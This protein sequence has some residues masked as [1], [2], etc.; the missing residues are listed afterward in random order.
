MKTFFG[1]TFIDK[2]AL[3]EA[4]IY[5]PIKLEYYRIENEDFNK[6]EYGIEIVK[7]EYTEDEVIV[8]NK[9]LENLTNNENIVNKILDMFKRNEVTPI[10]A[11]DIIHDLLY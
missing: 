11:K 5:N 4:N 3:E 7:T 9:I 2:L 1:G 6:E 10:S 8:E